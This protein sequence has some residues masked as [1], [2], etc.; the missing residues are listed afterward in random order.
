MIIYRVRLKDN[1]LGDNRCTKGKA[2]RDAS[3]DENWLAAALVYDAMVKKLRYA[4]HYIQYFIDIDK[5]CL[6]SL[7]RENVFDPFFLGTM[8]SIIPQPAPAFTARWFINLWRL[9]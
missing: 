3:F 8:L 2:H 6:V 4:E 5:R 7:L 9:R 1:I